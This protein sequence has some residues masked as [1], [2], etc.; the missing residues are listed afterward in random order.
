MDIMLSERK[1]G[2]ELGCETLLP[3]YRQLIFQRFEDKWAVV[4]LICGSGDGD[5]V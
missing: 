5:E 4:A 2:T 1:G 3:Y